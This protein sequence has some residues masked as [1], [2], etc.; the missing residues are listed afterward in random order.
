MHTTINQTVLLEKTPECSVRSLHKSSLLFIPKVRRSLQR[1]HHSAT[2]K[3][4]RRY[5]QP[6]VFRVDRTLSTLCVQ[7]CSNCKDSFHFFKYVFSVRQSWTTVIRIDVSCYTIGERF[8][9]G[10]QPNAKAR[11]NDLSIPRIQYS[12]ASQ[13]YNQRLWFIDKP[14]NRSRLKFT[15]LLF[16]ILSKDLFDSFTRSLL[17]P[18]IVSMEFNSS[19]VANSLATVDFPEPR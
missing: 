13:R 11:F 4:L 1:P 6:I 14:S 12:S 9:P 16:A 10:L 2:R 15:K 17:D 19:L 3:S 5:H 8:R 7:R 18:V